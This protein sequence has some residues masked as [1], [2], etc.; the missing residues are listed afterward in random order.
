M[1]PARSG[2]LG[3]V[4][5]IVTGATSGLGA[6][7]AAALADAG[8]RVMVTGREESRARAAAAALGPQALGCR[9]DVREEESIAV[10]VDRAHA[11]WGGIDL[12]V[13]NAGIGMRT[14]NPRFMSE[15]QPFWKVTADGFRD[16]VDTK[17]AGC[18]LMARAVVPSMLAAG[19]GRIVNISMS[20]G[21]MVRRGFVPY[22]PAGAAVEALSRVMAADLADT[23]VKVNLLLPGGATRTGMVP[24]EDAEELG[25]RLLDPAIMGPPIVWLASAEAAE[26]HDQ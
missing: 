20:E 22:G 12:L 3:G 26:I 9:L 17:L 25:T 5:A 11:E 16:V 15:P 10:C 19:S 4:R 23:P 21:T 18:F 1:S 2:R 8:A 13:N 7:M 6:A 24:D 14:V